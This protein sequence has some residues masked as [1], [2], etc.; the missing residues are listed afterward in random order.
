MGTTK[1]VG[2]AKSF[3][4]WMMALVTTA[5]TPGWLGVMA[6]TRPSSS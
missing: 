2:G 5:G 4:F 1:L 6:L 3:M